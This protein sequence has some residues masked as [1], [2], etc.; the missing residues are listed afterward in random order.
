MVNLK[1]QQDEIR[2]QFPG[3]HAVLSSGEIDR[4]VETIQGLKEPTKNNGSASDSSSKERENLTV[5][6]SSVSP[7]EESSK[8]SRK[9]FL[10]L[11]ET[12]RFI[13]TPPHY[14]YLKIAE[15]CRK[16]C[17][18]CIIPKLKG[19]LQSKPVQQVVDEFQTVLQHGM[20]KEVILI[21]QDLG[22]YGKDWKSRRNDVTTSIGSSGSSRSR[23]TQLL[24]AL[25]KS[26]DENDDTDLQQLN[27]L[28]DPFWLRL[29]YLYPDEITPDLIDLMERDMRIARYVDLPIQHSHNDILKAMRRKTSSEQIQDTIQT[30]RRR[31]PDI[32]IRTSLMVGFP[33]ETEEHFQHLLKFVCDYRLD[34]VGVFMYSN[35]EMAYSS[36][37]DNHVSE[38]VKQDRYRRL[39]KAQWQV[40]EQK[41]Q[42]WV[43]ERKRL[44]VVIEG[45]HEQ[46]P[47]R[48]VGR[49]AGQ[50]PDIDG[51]VLLEGQ[52]RVFGGERY[53]VEVTGYDGYDL[54]A[55]V[56]QEE[57]Q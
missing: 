18:F 34:H 54:I 4:I 17:S 28:E 49:H 35:E 38:E 32:S 1:R 44:R 25:L 20:A 39:M 40:V 37:L 13:S 2:N 50:C 8:S 52:P 51:Q 21:A 57:K 3:V 19:R 36:R 5:P 24:E 55:K 11:G 47:T 45:V 56:L 12:P 6:S 29:L 7:V 23:L 33:G 30:L 10:E 31:L 14:F 9:S 15:G 46:D 43:K 42:A 16:Q 22:D 53:W 27:D 41:H 48:I 26:M